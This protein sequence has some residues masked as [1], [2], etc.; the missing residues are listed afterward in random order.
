[1]DKTSKGGLITDRPTTGKPTRNR[2]KRRNR[3]AIVTKP[4]MR[5]AGVLGEAWRDVT[6]GTSHVC[7][8]T[9]TLV[10]VVLLCVGADLAS[11]TSIQRQADD[12][13]SSGGST[14]TITAEGRID[15]AACDRLGSL[16]GV[17]A[18]GA[19][20]DTGAKLVF[21]ALPSTG[22]PIQEATPSAI[23]VFRNST[24]GARDMARADSGATGN[25]VSMDGAGTA[26]GAS[27]GGVWLSTEAAQ[28]IGTHAGSQIALR[29][30][31][32]AD[33]AG[34]Y[35][36]PDD[37]RKSEYAYAAVTPVSV[38][39]DAD[40]VEG[41]RAGGSGMFDQCWVK[42]WPVPANLES[43]LRTA[44]RANETDAREQ[45]VVA[46]LNTTHGRSYDAAAAFR[47]RLTV[48]APLVAGVVA[49]L[50]GAAAVWMRRL[51][52]A[53]S[54]HCGV[55]KAA[56]VTQMLVEASVWALATTVPCAPVLAWMWLGNA[57]ADAAV[58]AD[59]LLRVPAAAY[60]GAMA[61]TLLCALLVRER[62]LFRYFK[63][64]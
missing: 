26:D 64:R 11:I 3:S 38:D 43:L 60:A 14:F 24:S 17:I 41:L 31:R 53:S 33:I 29:D 46:Q 15:G 1:M 55:P 19:T 63:N 54:L 28:P 8:I 9:F 57:D 44:V 35:D 13:V 16:D 51:E 37:G 5:L 2:R 25:V 12:F 52:L 50:T 47:G 62:R 30:G 40:G 22:V 45:P 49:L 34:I 20:R 36:W 21:A 59:T 6:S 48:W 42:A 58:L 18:A 61:G 56:M 23:G 32:T 39:A 7:A 4:R 10:C 27:T